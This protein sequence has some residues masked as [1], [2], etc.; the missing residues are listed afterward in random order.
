L[1]L[2]LLW[3]SRLLLL[4]AAKGRQVPLMSPCKARFDP[5]LAMG[6]GRVDPSI[7]V[8]KGRFH[9]G[10]IL[11][12]GRLIQQFR[13]AWKGLVLSL[14]RAWEGK[15]VEDDSKLA[16]K[17]SSWRYTAHGK[18]V[19]GATCYFATAGGIL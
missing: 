12:D 18:L 7:S 16:R 2:T 5:G 6:K 8:C 19:D 13:W 4:E 14:Y 15:G 17:G 11:G 3:L 9:P 1:N 10:S